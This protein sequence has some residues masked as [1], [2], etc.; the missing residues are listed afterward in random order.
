VPFDRHAA[1][2]RFEAAHELIGERDLRQHDD[3]L[4]A[5]LQRPRHRLEINFR[6]PRAGDAVEQRRREIPR[7]H[8]R[9]QRVHRRRLLR[10]E[11]GHAVKRIGNGRA[12][13]RYRHLDEI[14][15]CNE[16]VDDRRGA[17]R[18]LRQRCFR[19]D[20]PI[21]R[22]LERSLACG[23]HAPR[24]GRALHQRNA[25]AG[26]HRLERSARAHHHPHRHAERAQRVFGDPFGKA[27]RDLRQRRHVEPRGHRLELLR[28][29][30]L[31]FIAHRPVPYDADAA[32]R[33][34]RHQHE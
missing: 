6:L 30:G 26:F 28:I 23:R 1:E 13:F 9:P 21:S 14:A 17:F 22:N 24:I 5:V 2:T 31:A 27:Q 4:F 15:R 32:L 33:T 29:D 34:E 10:N 18:R 8:R 7:I 3:G 16:P 20:R 11:L 25:E 19:A 12:L